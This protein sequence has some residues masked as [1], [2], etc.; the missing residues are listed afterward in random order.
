[1]LY[2][3]DILEQINTLYVIDLAN[4]DYLDCPLLQKISVS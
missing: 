1:M 2:H 4:L 3:I